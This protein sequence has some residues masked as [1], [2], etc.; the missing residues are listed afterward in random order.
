MQVGVAQFLEFCLDASEAHGGAVPVLVAHNMTYDNGMLLAGCWQSGLNVP[1]EWRSLCTW[2]MA[3]SMGK[4]FTELSDLKKTLGALAMHFGCALPSAV[5][6]AVCTRASEGVWSLH[7]VIGRHST[8]G[9][10]SPKRHTLQ[11]TI[12]QRHR[13]LWCRLLTDGVRE[14]SRECVGIDR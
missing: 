10:L 5:C 14:C 7:G 11:L 3:K 2:R 1:P 9:G 8:Q 12:A 6:L 4:S 13:R